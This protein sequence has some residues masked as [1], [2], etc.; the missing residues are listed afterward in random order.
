MNRPISILSVLLLIFPGAAFATDISVMPASLSVATGSS[1]NVALMISGL[2]DL[3]TPSLGTYDLNV[4][5][6]AS[7]LGFVSAS[8]GDPGFGDQLDLSGFGTF[9]STTPGIGTVDLFELSFDSP[10]TLDSLQRGA[11][12]LAN[13]TFDALGPGTSSLVL[14]VNALGDAFGNSVVASLANGRVSV[15]AG[16]TTTVPTPGTPLLIGAGLLAL[17]LRRDGLGRGYNVSP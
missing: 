6:D 16:S 8:Y 7:V 17:W 9:A 15:T 14:G 4:A 1:V 3:G 2:T 11:F 10:A 5:Y 13:L 12:T